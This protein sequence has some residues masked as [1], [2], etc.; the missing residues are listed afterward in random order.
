MKLEDYVWDYTNSYEYM[1]RAFKGTFPPLIITCAITGGIQGKEANPN[2]PEEPEE[3]ADQTYEAYKAGATMVHIHARNPELLYEATGNPEVFY[4]I[5]KMI[6]ERCPD[7]IINASTGGGL[8][9]TDEEKM[10]CLEAGPEVASLNLTPEIYK[11]KFKAREAP[12]KHP[13]PA[14]IANG[15]VHVTFDSI[16]MYAERMKNKGI[17]PELEFYNPSNF[18]IM[19]DLIQRELIEPT[20]LT[21]FV[22]GSQAASLPT[23]ENAINMVRELPAQSLFT[24]IGTGGYQLPMN[25]V[26]ILLGGHVRV[27]MEDNV[28]YK[29]G[30]LLKNNAEAVHRI[31]RIA[32]ELNRPIATPAQAREMMG[33]SQT[34]TTY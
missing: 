3:Q 17:K 16:A 22:I 33:L 31:I 27:G 7:I 2:L 30:Q 20:Y 15:L 32:E 11:F 13:K 34:P 14:E 26:G 1:Q 21:Q 19:S 8:G 23:I 9:M 24:M 18:Y 12:L 5:F 6:R 10:A 4:T 29:R 25:M 28:Y